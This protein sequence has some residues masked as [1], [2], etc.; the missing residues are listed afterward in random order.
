MLTNTSRKKYHVTRSSHRPRTRTDSLVQTQQSK[1]DM[2]FGTCNVTCHYRSGWL[3][4]SARDLTAYKL[5]LLGVQAFRLHKGGT[6]RAGNYN[7]FYVKKRK[8]SIRNRIFCSTQNSISSQ[9]S[10]VCYI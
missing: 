2:R 3:T 7:Y 4:A 1:T 5:D 9:T 8:S 6:V 10:T